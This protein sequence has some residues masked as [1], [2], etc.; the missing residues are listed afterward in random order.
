MCHLLHHVIPKSDQNCTQL[1]QW[2]SSRTGWLIS[3]TWKN[4]LPQLTDLL[5]FLDNLFVVIELSCNWII[6]HTIKKKTLYGKMFLSIPS[7][8]NLPF[9]PLSLRKVLYN[10]YRK[11]PKTKTFA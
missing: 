4:K 8:V 3:N 6:F 11:E 5:D 2:K 9:S 10:E 1:C 7:S